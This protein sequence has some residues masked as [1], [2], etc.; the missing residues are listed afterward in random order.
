M[1]NHALVLC[2]EHVIYCN[3]MWQAMQFY[4][5]A[6]SWGPMCDYAQA[7]MRNENHRG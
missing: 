7:Q 2:E 5:I 6:V 1:K 3:K 4:A